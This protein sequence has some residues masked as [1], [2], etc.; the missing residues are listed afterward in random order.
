[1][2]TDDMHGFG[3]VDGGSLILVKSFRNDNT[4]LTS[5]LGERN[6]ELGTIQGAC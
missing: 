2:L 1:M 4:S 3:T 5:S 6:M